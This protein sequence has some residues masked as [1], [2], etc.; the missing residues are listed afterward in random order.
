MDRVNALL[1]F[2]YTLLAHEVTAALESVGLDPQSGFLHRDRPGRESLALDIMEELRSHFA[3]R[4]TLN[5]INRN[6]VDGDGFVIKGK[7]RGG[8]G[9][10]HKKR[11]PHSL[12]EA[13]TGANHS[14]LSG[15]ES[16][17]W[18]HTVYPGHAFWH[19]TSGVI[20]RITR[21]LSGS[22]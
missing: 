18:A 9:R 16:A 17:A 7:R 12:A 10:Q 6:Q 15:R 3:D 13:Q 8:D 1:S 19:G 20:L 21:H 5:L 11:S 2:F 22:R 14:S 4:L